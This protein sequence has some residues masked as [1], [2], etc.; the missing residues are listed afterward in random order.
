L[1]NIDIQNIIELINSKKINEANAELEKILNFTKDN[2][3]LFNIYGIVLL[4]KNDLKGAID[5]FKKAIDINPEFAEGYYNLGT[6][7]FRL[8]DFNS[9]I[10]Y[11]KKA[12]DIK[13]N[14]FEAYFNLSECYRNLEFYDESIMHLNQCIK[15]DPKD[16][17][18]YNNLGL[19]YH[20]L[21]LFSDAL[22]NFKKC[23]IINPD[24][25]QAYNN[26]G[27]VYL[28]NNQ[29]DDAI[30]NF[31]K[32][33]NVKIDFVEAYNNLGMALHK[34]KKYSEAVSILEKGILINNKFTNLYANLANSLRSL[35]KVV[36][37]ISLLEEIFSQDKNPEILPILGNNYC[38]IGEVSK[39]INYYRES[40]KLNPKPEVYG[41]LLFNLNY[42]EDFDFKEYFEA[43]DKI[44]S[45]YKKYDRK[46]NYNNNLKE[47]NKK[48][49][50]GFV[51]GDFREH[52]VGY[53]IFEVVKY[54]SNNHDFELYAYY[55]DLEEDELNNKFKKIFKFWRSI[56]NMSDSMVIDQIKLDQIQILIDLSGYTEGN[57]LQVFFNKPAPVQVSWA[58]YLASSG[59]KEIDY[60][61]VDEHVAANLD[62]KNQFTEKLWKLKNTWSV[63]TPINNIVSNNIPAKTNGYVTF[64]SFNNLKKINNK[65][66]KLWS[67]IL[68]QCKDSKLLLVAWQFKDKKFTEYFS[69]FFLDQGV[70]LE[71]LVLKEEISRNDLLNL[72]NTI[73]IS[74]DTFPYNGGTTSL[75]SIFMCVPVLTKKGNTF[76]SK[77]GDSVNTSIG[78]KDWIAN[79]DEDYV[80]K[81]V[82]FAKDFIKIQE[83]K[84][85]LK[86]NRSNFKLFDGKDFADQLSN[87]FKKMLQLI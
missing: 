18:I 38:S 54:L 78:L 40:L 82:N 36:D 64:G 70:K 27:A 31:N 17:E 43:V 75:E 77:C 29:L 9:A 12:I 47:S 63:L 5:Q 61:I 48:I 23:L 57:R 44:K 16:F 1:V 80:L 49:K 34:Q 10:I 66:I 30:I 25:F 41:S 53:Q 87:S 58:G 42:I 37:S 11:L 65:I 14:Y 15:L 79:N 3:L 60:I 33:I 2:F 85:Y 72:Y 55:N 84:N 32:C 74:L 22:T 68:Y 39:G 8:L 46:I 81:A 6:A 28:D 83:V 52:A 86:N 76:L 71:Q 21:N 13:K 4:Q 62:E 7:L 56:K 73:D 45:S 67:Q 59:L 26:I 19:V 35:G 51:S 24:F 69:N 50:L 20:K